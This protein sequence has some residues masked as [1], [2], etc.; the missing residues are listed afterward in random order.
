MNKFEEV[1]LKDIADV[2]LSNVDKKYNDNEKEVRLC[3][4]IDIYN[5]WEIKKSMYNNFMIATVKKEEFQKFK[6]KKGMI[7]L[8]KDSETREDI[9]I[10]SY[11]AD[12]F[13]DV[14]LGYHTILIV[15]KKDKVNSSYLNAYLKNK[16]ARK[17]F[18]NQASGS[19]QRYT[20][21][22]ESVEN[23]K[24]FL[25]NMKVQNEIGNFISNINQKIDII[26]QEND[27]F[28]KMITLIYNYWFLQFDFPDENGKPYKSSGGKMVW[29]EEL[30][31]EIPED[32]NV[33]I[34]RDMIKENPKSNI[35]ASKI[36]NENLGNI[37]FFIS[38]EEIHN[39]TEVLVKGKNLFLNTGGNAGIKFF[40][41]KAAYSTD[42]WSIRCIDNLEI[43]LYL[44]LKSIKEDSF[45]KKYFS[46]TGLKHLQK[47][48][49]K[50]TKILEPKKEIIDK[51]N[52]IVDDL[53]IKKSN[54]YYENK[55]LENL[56]DFLLPL[57][58]NGQVTFKND[59]DS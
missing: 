15:P 49:L 39:C 59:K 54:I 23:L 10:A 40:Y 41:G 18:A 31:K 5:N 24:V 26:K 56:K 6:L 30:K 3:N 32:W 21:S 35:K 50:D 14:V 57:L 51:F 13:E 1:Q 9:G 44:Y 29:N 34:I 55:E 12:D 27:L 47:D 11:V 52:L 20:L 7:A 28:E 8:T 36:K 42:T 58:M 33:R 2:Y 17:Y 46:G 45:Y 38:G 43:Y 16:V 4:F 53:Y 25:P 19:G 37:P 48:L 22:K